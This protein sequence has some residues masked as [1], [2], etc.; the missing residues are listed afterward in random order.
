MPARRPPAGAVAALATS[1]QNRHASKA[2]AA[3]A[4]AKEARSTHPLGG[5]ELAPRTSLRAHTALP[6]PSSFGTDEEDEDDE[7]DEDEGEVRFAAGAESRSTEQS[8]DEDLPRDV[9]RTGAPKAKPA[10]TNRL[11]AKFEHCEQWIAS[12][13]ARSWTHDPTLPFV[14]LQQAFRSSPTSLGSSLMR[15][16]AI[17]RSIAIRRVV[18]RPAADLRALPVSLSA[19]N[20]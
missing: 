11:R 9:A 4:A 3:A 18:P 8:E 5:A 17:L 6:P 20:T 1:L 19:A 12:K 16:A 13:V 2:Q 14:S 7:H 10:G 15:A